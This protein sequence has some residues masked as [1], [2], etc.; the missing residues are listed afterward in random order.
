MDDENE[1]SQTDDSDSETNGEYTTDDESDGSFILADSR[2][3][4]HRDSLGEVGLLSNQQA[5]RRGRGGLGGEALSELSYRRNEE[6]ASV[7]RRLRLAIK[8]MDGVLT[9]EQVSA[10]GAPLL[11][12]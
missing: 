5:G 8:Q 3:R 6:L 12:P 7:L 2:A 4:Y 10:T 11:W 9:E 1:D